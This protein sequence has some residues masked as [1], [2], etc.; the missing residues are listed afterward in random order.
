MATACVICGHEAVEGG[1]LCAGHQSAFDTALALRCRHEM[2]RRYPR[3]S[4]WD[5][6]DEEDKAYDDFHCSDRTPTEC[7]EHAARN[8]LFAKARRVAITRKRAERLRARAEAAYFENRDTDSDLAWFATSQ[9]VKAAKVLSNGAE[10]LTRC[11]A[12]NKQ[13]GTRCH[14]WAEGEV[15]FENKH[16]QVCGVHQKGFEIWNRTKLS[17]R[18]GPF[19]RDQTGPIYA[20]RMEAAVALLLGDMA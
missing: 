9:I 12:L 1:R 13:T 20:E 6:T 11:E 14:H 3:P 19:F 16:R 5:T 15:R 7:R 4:I 17:R 8:P 2:A 10:R 18:S